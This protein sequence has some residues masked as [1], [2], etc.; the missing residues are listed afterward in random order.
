MNVYIFYIINF[1]LYG[2]IPGN[3]ERYVVSDLLKQ[4]KIHIPLYQLFQLSVPFFRKISSQCLQLLNLLTHNHHSTHYNQSLKLIKQKK[5]NLHTVVFSQSHLLSSYLPAQQHLTQLIWPLLLN[6]T[7]H[8]FCSQM[9]QCP[10]M[11]TF[12]SRE[13]H[14]LPYF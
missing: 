14:L 12:L 8:S 3:L 6:F 1:T 4:N 7:A 13:H 9:L 2:I 5:N 10:R 11:P